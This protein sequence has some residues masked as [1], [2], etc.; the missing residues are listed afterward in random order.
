MRAADLLAR[1]SGAWSA[2]TR[3]PF[4]L[5]VR[6]GTVPPAAFDTW[7]VQ[8]AFFVA[9]L[10]WFQARL[11]ARAP[12]VAQPVLAG[13]CVA[14]VDELAWFADRAVERGLPASAPRRAATEDYRELLMRLDAAPEATAVTALWVL[15]RVYL[16]A[17]TAAVPGAPEFRPFVAHWTTPEF[18]AYVGDLERAVDALL[19]ADDVA[20]EDL[21]AVIAEVLAAEVS[22]WDMAVAAP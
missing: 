3:H 19:A 8:D 10:L 2:A 22:F 11:L 21:E 16:E 7:L 4:L 1:V 5:G 14:L 13:G 17:W 18:A 9:D 15:E 12:R 6:D 20:P